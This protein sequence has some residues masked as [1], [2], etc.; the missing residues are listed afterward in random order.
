MPLIKLIILQY[1]QRISYG[2]DILLDLNKLRTFTIVAEQQSITRAAELLFRTQPA[3]SAQLKDLQQD[4]QLVLFERKSS[5]IYLTKEGQ[6]LYNYAKTR[7]AEIDDIVL[8]LQHDKHNLQGK[9]HLAVHWELTQH[10]IPDIVLGFRGHYPNVRFDVTQYDDAQL[11]DALIE[12]RADIGFSIISHKKEFLQTTP[13]LTFERDLI[14]AREYLDSRAE[15]KNYEDVLKLDIIGFN[16][17]LEDVRFWLKKNGHKSLAKD[18][19]EVFN[20]ICVSEINTLHTLVKRGLGIGF[21]DSFILKHELQRQDLVKV[22]ASS[23]PINISVDISYRK[24]RTPSLLIDTFLEYLES[25]QVKLM[26][27]V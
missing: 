8:R 4:I 1:N 25:E 20:P 18:V 26:F 13:F 2:R 15:V 6:S 11:S 3:I 12:N 14:G 7:I 17:R 16:E 23:K 21:C 9:I 27:G 22:I 19:D 5:R 24:V 10:L